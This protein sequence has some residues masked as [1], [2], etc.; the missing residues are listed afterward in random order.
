[1]ATTRDYY[2]ILGVSKSATAAEIKSAYRKAALKY[3]PDRN[4]EAGAE[5]KFKEMNAAY[6]VLSDTQKRAAYDQYGHAAFQQGGPSAGGNPFSGGFGGSYQ[7]NYGGVGNPFEGMGFDP[8]D[9]FDIFDSF[10]GGGSRRARKPMYSLQVDF[11]D[12]VK[13][14]TKTVMIDGKERTIKIPAGS[15]DGVRI[16]FNEFDIRLQVSAHPTFKRDGD[17]IYV[18]VAVPFWQAILGGEIVAPT[19]DG[20]VR[21]KIRP[22]TQP[23]T[24]IRLR[25]QGVQRL[26]GRGRGDEYLR[27]VV[28]I[29]EKVSREQREA[30]SA[31]EK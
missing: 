17:D 7:Y 27:L 11:M 19:I 21:V 3:H 26:Q 9:P 30:L 1:M 14:A 8:N 28:T 31:F 25:D 16:R 15:D 24:M 22:G 4:K 2:E 20:D 5:E 13:G 29:P 23:A 10:F 12:A 18:D 6:E